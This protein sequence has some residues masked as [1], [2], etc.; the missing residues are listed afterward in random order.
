MGV[1][2]VAVGPGFHPKLGFAEFVTK[3]LTIVPATT[4]QAP[5]HPPHQFAVGNPPTEDKVVLLPYAKLI[6]L[7]D[8]NATPRGVL[9]EAKSASAA[10]AWILQIPF[11]TPVT[12]PEL[13]TV[14]TLALS[15]DQ[16]NPG[17][18]GI[19]F[20]IVGLCEKLERSADSPNVKTIWRKWMKGPDYT[21]CTYS[22]H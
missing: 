10:C 17:A 11:A 19:A 13:F 20:F 18:I 9:V 1:M 21:S 8:N 22:C 16:L 12:N 2:I 14:A 6:E 7:A 3:P 15:L 4:S 5:G